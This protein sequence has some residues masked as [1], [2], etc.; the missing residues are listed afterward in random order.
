[1]VT[2]SDAIRTT[3]KPD[4]RLYIFLAA[5]AVVIAV[6]LGY[7]KATDLLEQRVA[8]EVQDRL[9]DAIDHVGTCRVQTSLSLCG[10]I[11]GKIDSVTVSATNVDLRKGIVAEKLTATLEGV[12]VDPLRRQLKGIDRV[13]FSFSATKDQLA[14][15]LYNKYPNA[16]FQME[17]RSGYISVTTSA[18]IRGKSVWIAADLSPKV[19]QGTQVVLLIKRVFCNAPVSSQILRKYLESRINP[20]FDISNAN[21]PGQLTSVV[22]TPRLITV[23][24]I[25]RIETLKLLNKADN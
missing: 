5:F 20:V 1:M 11:R 18:V 10:V 16:K 25:G 15:Y 6:G 4:R 12:R 22:V 14:S 9:A 21:L 13:K 2:S 7:W 17:L 23:N 19:R 24:G 8:R 3:R